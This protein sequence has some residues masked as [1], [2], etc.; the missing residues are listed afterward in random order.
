MLHALAITFASALLAATVLPF[1]SEVVL[2]LYLK[3]GL[4]PTALWLA[5][6]AG[7]TLGSMITWAMGRWLSHFENRRWFPIKARQLHHAQGWFNRY[8]IWSL[9]MAWLPV[10][11][12]ALPFIAGIMRSPPALTVILIAIGKGLRYLVVIL[13]AQGLL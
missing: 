9:L 8:G 6:T 2:V 12:D 4:D 5:A 1:Y 10:G 13:A 7:N 3:Q 11:G